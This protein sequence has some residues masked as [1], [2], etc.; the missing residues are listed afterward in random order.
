MTVRGAGSE[1]VEPCSLLNTARYSFP[2]CEV[3]VGLMLSVPM[4][5]PASAV[6]FDHVAPPS[7]ETCHRTLSAPQLAGLV[8]AAVNDA[9]D[10]AVT[11]S[12]D[13]F[14]V[15]IGLAEQTDPN[16]AP[17]FGVPIPVGPS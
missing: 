13:G 6:S 8:A 4:V 5:F 14:I 17:P 9:P 3:E 1:F 2:D 7:L 15:T 11:V 10:G 12:S 16:S